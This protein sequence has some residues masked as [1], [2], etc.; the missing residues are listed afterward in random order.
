MGGIWQVV[1][2]EGIVI[3]RS[4]GEIGIK[5]RPVRREYEILLLKLIRG[6][7]RDEG[8]PFS[9]IWR[10]A[11][12]VFIKTADAQRAARLASRVFGVASASPGI[13]TDA[14]MD[15][16]IDAGRAVAK[17]MVRGT[18]AVRC[19]RTG[20]HP[21][22]SKDVAAK[23]GEEILN[24]GRPL[25]VN[26]NDPDQEVSVEIRNDLA[27]I[28][29]EVYPGP[30]GYPIGTQDPALG[31][32][33]ETSDSVIASWCIMKRGS[34]ITALSVEQEG[35]D[36]GPIMANLASLSM[37]LP[38]RGLDCLVAT[39]PGSLGESAFRAFS[40]KVADETASMLGFGATVSG[41]VPESLDA[42]G[43]LS[44]NSRTALMFPLIAI[45]A[46]CL[47]KWSSLI[48]LDLSRSIRYG[49]RLHGE[50]LDPSPVNASLT[51]IRRFTVSRGRV[52][53]KT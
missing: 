38:S 41:M 48:G 53:P 8:V 6:M 45:D 46:A 7:L 12:R 11:G 27:M 47:Q 20:S 28:Y 4:G 35:R 33:D 36:M 17:G 26:L 14:S 43:S 24:L 39:A 32:I 10:D 22:S 18:F 42:L 3:V 19:R 25:R 2:M 9:Q 5:S 52:I 23:L 30:D 15:S 29:S 40:L 16:I 50:P 13:A 21:Y 51:G 37:W 1:E 49:A 31:I 44:R 34:P